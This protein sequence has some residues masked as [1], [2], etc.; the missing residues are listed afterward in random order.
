LLLRP[1]VSPVAW[2]TFSLQVLLLLLLLLLP[3]LQHPLCPLLA[4][5]LET[6]HLLHPVFEIIISA[7]WR[8]QLCEIPLILGEDGRNMHLGRLLLPRHGSILCL[9]LQSLLLAS[10]FIMGNLSPEQ[11][12]ISRVGRRR[13]CNRQELVHATNIPSC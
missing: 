9:S 10:Y 12:C 13:R 8:P 6:L 4:H 11:A 5:L 7:G 1:P 2:I 3:W